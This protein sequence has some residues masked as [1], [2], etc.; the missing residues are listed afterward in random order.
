M[1]REKI[2]IGTCAQRK[3]KNFLET[4]NAA[5]TPSPPS[6]A[7]TLP[8]TVLSSPSEPVSSSST[9]RRHRRRPAARR[10][11]PS[12]SPQVSTGS[13]PRQPS[14]VDLSRVSKPFT[15]SPAASSRRGVA[16]DEQLAAVVVE[17]QP[18]AVS[19]QTETR[20]ASLLCKPNPHPSLHPS[21]I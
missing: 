18:E 13:F 12:F 16:T 2:G 3:P 15:W 5:A 17:C 1:R 14:R 8:C 20:P 4:V 9:P 10:T 6:A 21:L 11:P 7:T 19:P